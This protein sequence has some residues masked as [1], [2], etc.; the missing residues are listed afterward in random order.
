MDGLNDAGILHYPLSSRDPESR[1]EGG[2]H[3]RPL[4][5]FL[6]CE[7]VVVAIQGLL[8]LFLL[9]TKNHLFLLWQVDI[10]YP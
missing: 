3:V 5:D 7:A 9:S 1:E 2:D 10:H 4:S 6:N 8:H